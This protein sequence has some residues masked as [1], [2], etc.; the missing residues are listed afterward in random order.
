MIRH[1]FNF[2]A[3]TALLSGA[4]C[5][6]LGQTIGKLSRRATRKN[7]LLSVGDP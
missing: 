2:P 1:G 5:V 6:G 7:R 4:A 3:L